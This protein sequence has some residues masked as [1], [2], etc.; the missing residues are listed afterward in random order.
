M[1][2]S[3]CPANVDGSHDFKPVM[4]ESIPPDSDIINAAG[5]SDEGDDG[6]FDADDRVKL[7][8]ALTTRRY[9]VVCSACGLHAGG[10]LNRENI[11]SESAESDES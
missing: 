2:G 1:N 7:I 4:V 11:S 10:F 6:G 8:L 5:I 3:K 9:A